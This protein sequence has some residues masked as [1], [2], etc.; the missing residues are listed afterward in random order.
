MMTLATPTTAPAAADAP[1]GPPAPRPA[2]IS[3]ALHAHLDGLAV[4]AD[5][6]Y[7]ACAA[8]G[9]IEDPVFRRLEAMLRQGGDGA[10]DALSAMQM[11]LI[12]SGEGARQMQARTELYPPL[13]GLFT[14]PR[15]LCVYSLKLAGVFAVSVTTDPG[16]AAAAVA[17]FGPAVADLLRMTAAVASGDYPPGMDRAAAKRMLRPWPQ[18]QAQYATLAAYALLFVLNL[19]NSRLAHAHVVTLMELCMPPLLKLLASTLPRARPLSGLAA[20]AISNLTRIPAL[21]M[22]AWTLGGGREGLLRTLVNALIAFESSPVVAGCVLTLWHLSYPQPAACAA[23][24]E[25]AVPLL[26]E[27][28]TGEVRGCWL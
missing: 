20:L 17:V 8:S 15:V 21:T 22:T 26:L 27:L 14:S 7:E 10:D 19:G 24:L 5:A 23:E 1:D 18:D 13:A 4:T 12:L 3:Q 11:T 25:G 9:S 6:F 28:F 2:S 16:A